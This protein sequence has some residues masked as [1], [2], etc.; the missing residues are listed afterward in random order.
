MKNSKL[1][2]AGPVITANPRPAGLA[3]QVG[4]VV[5]TDRLIVAAN[6]DRILS[7][8]LMNPITRVLATS[9]SGPGQVIH[10]SGIAVDPNTRNIFV[11]DSSNHRVQKFTPNFVFIKAWGKFGTGNSEFNDPKG[12]AVDSN[13]DIYV[14]DEDNH[15]V[16]KFDL[17][18]QFIKSWGSPVTGDG[19]FSLPWD[20]AFN[21]LTGSILVSDIRND[22][23]QTFT[24][25]GMFS[26]KVIFG[27]IL[28]Q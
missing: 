7:V 9:G 11:A 26:G 20:I 15:R 10:A 22:N 6:N 28:Q 12:I 1:N 24:T 13:N 8:N 21:S 19:Q 2:E 16:Q 14:V 17:N 3:V 5:G 25:D 18:G 27:P 23:I 4:S